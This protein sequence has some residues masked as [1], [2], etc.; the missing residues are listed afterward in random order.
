MSINKS[1]AVRGMVGQLERKVIRR[2]VLGN[3]TDMLLGVMRH[4]GIISFLDNDDSIGP[5]SRY[6]R[7]TGSGFNENLAREAMELHTL[8]SGGG[9]TEEDVTQLALILTGWSYVRGWEADNKYNGGKNR[10]RGKFIFRKKWHEPGAI[11]LMGKSYPATG[12]KQGVAALID[13]SRHPATA[14]HIAFK[15]VH[16][17]ITDEPTPEMV[18]PLKQAF[19]QSG[20]NLKQVALALLNLPEAFTAPLTK[21]RTPYELAIAQ[22][23]AVKRRVPRDKY[24]W[25]FAGPLYAMNNM[26]WECPSPEGYSDD[27]L[28]WLDPDGMTL[29]IDTAQVAGWVYGKKYRGSVTGLANAL[30]DSALSPETRERVAQA[31]DKSAALTML[32]CSPEFQR[33]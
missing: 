3:F 2:H 14:E 11:T 15:L 5:N 13:L 21:M 18:E 17:F 31:G 25:V 10:N 33:R 6:G 27:T 26:P 24:W 8:G 28:Y 20:G 32:F 1:T 19:L 7:K 9:Y 23:R 4:P 16:H 22:M 29:R 12:R 30:Y